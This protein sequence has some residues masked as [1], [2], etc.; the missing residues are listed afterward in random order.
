M[1]RAGAP[2]CGVSRISDLVD[3]AR[4]EREHPRAVAGPDLEARG[5]LLLTQV[6]ADARV[7]HRQLDQLG[8]DRG[9]EA[10]CRL[11]SRRA[12]LAGE[13]A[14]VGAE[15]DPLLRERLATVVVVLEVEQPARRG[16]GPREHGVD[17]VAVLAG[18]CPERRAA[19]LDRGEAC[20]VGLDPCGVGRQLAGDVAERGAG[21]GQ[22]VRQ[23]P[24]LGVVLALRLERSARRD[25]ER[26]GVV[27]A[28]GVRVGAQGVVGHGGRLAEL[29]GVAEPLGLRAEREVLPRRRGD[30]LDLVEPVAQQVG[31]LRPLARRGP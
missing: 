12:H 6:D 25:D 8:R 19:L 1:G 15:R 31:L 21:V 10:L 30:R 5:G 7:R 4:T 29:L 11:G 3:T 16:V 27:V 14:Q 26:Q 24:E 17:R 9:G 2:V 18:E 22:P 23:R 13:T 20:G 28:R